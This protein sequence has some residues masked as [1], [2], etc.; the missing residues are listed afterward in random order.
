LYFTVEVY[1]AI[2]NDRV[3]EDDIASWYINLNNF[4]KR[5]KNLH[6]PKKPDGELNSNT[7]DGKISNE[8]NDD[9]NVAEDDDA[10]VRD[11][12]PQALYN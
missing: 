9:G 1:E 12:E 6:T 5:R 8:E 2:F 4:R 7:S 10:G 3:A 11:E